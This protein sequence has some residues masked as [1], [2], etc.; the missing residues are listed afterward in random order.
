MN[1][2]APFIDRP[3]ASSLLAV[4]MVLLG[5]LAWRLLPVAPLPQ[6]D[7]PVI[8]VSASLPGA[9]PEN[10]ARTVTAPLERALGAIAGVN[11]ISSSSSQ[12][13]SRIL[14]EFDLGRDINA[15]ARDVQA[16]INLAAGDL[17]AGMPSPPSFIKLN[18]TQA[19]VMALALSSA[20]LSSGQLYDLASTVLAQKLAQVPGVGEVSVDGSSLPAVRVQLDPQA[21]T[22][23]GI[24]LD[25]VRQ[26]LA[27]TNS[28]RPRGALEDGALYWQV[29]TS[30]QLRRAADYRELLLR[31]QDGAAIRL[32]DVAEVLDSVENRYASGFHNHQPAV[33]LMIQRQVGA[34]IIRTVDALHAQMPALRALVPAEA[35]LQVVL[36]RSPGIRATLHAAHLTLL[37]AVALVVL[38]VFAFLGSPRAA[39][40]PSLAIPVSLIASFAV[41]YL[42]GFSLNNLSL[43][44]LIIAAGL[45]VDDAIVVLENISRH[46]ERG[47]PPLRAARLGAAE[48]GFTLLAMTLA[49][50]VVF[51]AILFMGGL[52]ARL[53]REF[54]ITLV[55]AMLLSLLVSL[56][57]TPALCAHLLRPG[58]V[59]TADG[60]L[61][62]GL[63]RYYLR[64]LHWALRVPPL[65][66]LVL[67]LIMA[68][69]VWLYQSLPKGML[70]TQDTGQLRAFARGD[71]GF[72]FQVMQPKIEIYRQ[73]LLAD[74]AVADVIGFS[75]GGR[76]ASNAQMMVRLKPR[77]ERDG[78]SSADVVARISAGL[79][80]VPGGM[81]FMSVEQDLFVPSPFGSGSEHELNLLSSDIGLLR[82]WRPIV[83]EAM[84]ALPEL[85][86]VRADSNAGTQQVVVDIDRETAARLGIDTRS[87]GSLLNNAFSQRQVATI[88]DRMNQYRV[89]ME[90]TQEMTGDPEAL[91]RIEVVTADGERVPLSAF[92]RIEY[93]QVNDRIRHESQFAMV[94]I[95]F[96]LAEGVSLQ[97]AMI[98]IDRAMAGIML[99]T[100]VQ[101][102]VGGAAQSFSGLLQAQPWLLLG[103]LVAVYL[104]LGILYESLIHPLTIL[105]TVPPAGIGALLALQLTGTEFS[106]VAL[107]GLF[108]LIGV[109][110]KN[111]ILMIDF[112][113][114]AQRRDGLTARAAIMSAAGIRLRPILMTNLAGLLGALP[115]L[116]GLG[117]GAEL[118][119]P[120]GLTII[121]GLAVSQLLTLYTTPVVYLCLEWLRRR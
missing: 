120:L 7:F 1:L 88:Y 50:T 113:I 74:P 75:G 118:R 58:M 89:V 55:A 17:P 46:I 27:D 90:V 35:E 12:G 99:P 92:T 72:S 111:A 108:L 41:M 36:D 77:A 114:A 51:I 33:I 117:E 81:M 105:S 2:A 60:G 103:A 116:L 104:V 68:G 13:A 52:L 31:W 25:E 42:Y 19:P 24:A 63:R 54:S 97:E 119:Q 100:A 107:L 53:F 39:L 59:G 96:G 28:L 32:G 110:M 71:D 64:S 8:H 57:L 69:G 40:I 48:V 49:L 30:G 73:Q 95:G 112:A 26:A 67:L 109:V 3:V 15:A 65:M 94:G 47:E 84:E 62:G 80:P 93:A 76:G 115:L 78:L 106:L 37:L 21:L 29:E 4:A 82:R 5:A 101:A 11:G 14:V 87:I 70:P 121:G 83:A 10:M 56:T 45:V 6:V 9:S 61:L 85:Q 23:Y 102:R 79:P 86:Q 44:A 43:T 18:P 20:T 34:N 16:A 66:L 91:R 38:V 22:H 98:A